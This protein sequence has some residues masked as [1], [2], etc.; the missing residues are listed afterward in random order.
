MLLVLVL[1][2]TT[3]LWLKACGK[4]PKWKQ[5]QLFRSITVFSWME[6]NFAFVNIQQN[7]SKLFVY[8]GHTKHSVDT[9]ITLMQFEMVWTLLEKAFFNF[10]ISR[11]FEIKSVNC[12]SQE[13]HD[14]NVDVFLVRC[15][16]IT[17]LPF[18]NSFSLIFLKNNISISKRCVK[19][20]FYIHSHWPRS[21][22]NRLI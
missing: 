12:S 2:S 11:K 15:H 1:K 17:N 5:S 13:K 16:H 3:K 18:I 19:T 21:H 14:Q 20:Y 22:P 7:S 8:L 6:R 10:N 9:N 4:W